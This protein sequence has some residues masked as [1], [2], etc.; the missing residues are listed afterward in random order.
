MN[1]IRQLEIA[2]R[3][4]NCRS[5]KGKPSVTQEFLDECYHK[6]P[7]IISRRCECQYCECLLAPR[8]LGSIG[9]AIFRQTE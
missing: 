4:N 1:I 2:L 7:L 9:F 5:A 6:A 8:F 3:P